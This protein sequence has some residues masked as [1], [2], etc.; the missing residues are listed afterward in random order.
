MEVLSG[1]ASIITVVTLALQS[2]TVIFDEASS[3][4]HGSDEVDRLAR[5]TSNLKKLLEV[6]KR[7]AEQA[8]STNCVAEGGLVEELTPLVGQ[9]AG[10]LREISP[11]FV[12]LQKDPNDRRWKKAKKSARLYLDSEGVDEIWSTLNHYVELLGTSLGNASV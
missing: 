11:K 1:V 5:A 4:S 8:R 10:A 6:I 9:C 3:I 2:T 7:L 12:Q